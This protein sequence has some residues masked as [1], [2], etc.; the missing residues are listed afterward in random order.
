MKLIV[1]GRAAGRPVV[2][3][4]LRL[5]NDEAETVTPPL[6]FPDLV[7]F[8]EDARESPTYHETVAGVEKA[9]DDAQGQL[10]RLRGL[11]NSNPDDDGPRAA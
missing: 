9:L 10:D 3:P 2:K 11:L 5:H 4:K 1:S 7:R 8:R 6:R